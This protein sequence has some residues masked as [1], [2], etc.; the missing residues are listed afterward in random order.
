MADKIL[1]IDD[2]FDTLKL[3]GMMLQKQGYQV[4]ASANGAQGLAQADA[5]NPD[6][7]LLDIMMPEMDGF[8][9]ARR[10][11]ANVLTNNTPI[12]M[13]TA[14]T[15]L[16]DKVTGFEAGADDYLTKPAHPVELVAHVKALL[17]SSPKGKTPSPALSAQGTSM[18]IAVLAPLKGQG[19]TMVSVNLGDALRILTKGDVIVAELPPG[20]GLLGM[21]MGGVNPKDLPELL[22]ADRA[23]I[24]PRK[25]QEY[26]I[27][28]KTGL[29]LLFSPVRGEEELLGF[30]PEKV[31]ALVEGMRTL[32][33][34]LILDLGAGLTPMAQRIIP[35]CN[36]ILMIVEPERNS[37]IQTRALIKEIADLTGCKENIHAILVD[38][39]RPG[40]PPNKAMVAE[41][42]GQTPLMIISFA[43]ELLE[44]ASRLFTSV[45]A[46]NSDSQAA[47]Q[48]SKL[49]A[50]M[51]F[52]EKKKL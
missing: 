32:A 37:V 51:L 39:I 45:V 33:P 42:L 23:E 25:I 10:L 7:I 52:F 41:L 40:T 1:I 17:E 11:R 28:H 4:I 5:E 46:S 48:F 16:D 36:I 2:D 26:L 24:T 44:T 3:V 19:G 27:T 12:L 6:L 50:A 15:Q 47:R 8:E 43:P 30:P 20:R 21:D 9:V 34:Y 31:K 18:T 35:T 38:R 22:S 49:A 29:R 13:F 14:K